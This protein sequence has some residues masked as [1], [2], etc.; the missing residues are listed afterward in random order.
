MAAVH[1]IV[2]L[3]KSECLMT[4]SSISS[5]VKV[6]SVVVRR[7]MQALT[8]AGIV[9]SKVGRDGGYFLMNP[10]DEITL[11]DVYSAILRK[12]TLSQVM[13]HTNCY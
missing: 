2:W 13:N 10:A 12:Y 7:I 3:A 5:L 1:V 4:S 8:K 11:G 6:H 9:E